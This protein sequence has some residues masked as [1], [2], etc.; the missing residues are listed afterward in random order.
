M[1][2]EGLRI[3]E[4]IE[5]APSET[6][7]DELVFTVATACGEDDDQADPA[8]IEWSDETARDAAL[9][10]FDVHARPEPRDKWAL[11]QFTV[12]VSGERDDSV[13]ERVASAMARLGTS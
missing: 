12:H 11:G 9:R 10:R 2:A 7:A 13:V 5:P 3:C 4:R 1:R 6:V 8:V